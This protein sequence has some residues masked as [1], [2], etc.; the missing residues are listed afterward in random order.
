MR[1]WFL[2]CVIASVASL[3]IAEES[4]AEEATVEEEQAPDA[5]MSDE[6]RARRAGVL[7]KIGDRAIT[8]G[9][10]EDRLNKQGP[11]RRFQ[12]NA[13]EKRR[14]FLDQLI[15]WELQAQEAERRG[16]GDDD[17]VEAQMKR[18]MS[19]MLLKREVE[20]QVRPDDVTEEEMRSYY[21]QHNDTFHR[22]ERVRAYH[23]V[24][25]DRS[26]AQDVLS[27]ML[28]EEVDTREFRR[29]AREM[30]EDPVTKRRGGDLRYFTRA[31]ERGDDDPEI[32]GPVVDATFE[33]LEKRRAL[34]ER[35]K[36]AGGA[37]AAINKALEGFNP[38]YPKLVKTAQGFHIIRFMGHRDAV[39]RD[40][41]EVS[42]QIRSRIWREKRQQARET[43]INELRERH[44]V[45]VNEAHLKLVEVDTAVGP[46]ARRRRG[47]MPRGPR[48]RRRGL[49][50]SKARRPSPRRRGGP[51]KR[52][53]RR[54]NESREDNNE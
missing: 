36:K 47:P 33:L 11:F 42:R 16:L 23:I 6:E 48:R 28:E 9:D 46:G 30:S 49:H 26:K 52:P 50:P 35:A 22:P 24:I 51:S 45:D 4:F 10:F 25:S 7:A 3:F 13:P 20:E 21:Q 41:E 34:Q 12:F 29:L 1:R 39:H 53:E 44:E 43:F 17:A 27:R 31:D 37:K 40:F 15:E 2:L 14:E 19:S 32:P 5:G 18:V 54:S 38:I 8:V